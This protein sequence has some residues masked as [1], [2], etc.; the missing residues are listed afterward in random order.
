MME[1]EGSDGGTDGGEESGSPG[2]SFRPQAVIFVHKWSFAIVGGRSCWQVVVFMHGWGVMSWVLIICMLGSSS[3]MLLFV[4]MVA[5]LGAGL[6]FV[7]TASSCMG[8]GGSFAGG[9]C[10]SWLGV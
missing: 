9:V 7:G 1:G 3:S 8:G 4:V 2:L 10:R 5:V 6:S